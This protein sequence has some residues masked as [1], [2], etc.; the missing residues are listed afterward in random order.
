MLRRAL[1]MGMLSQP[2]PTDPISGDTWSTDFSDEPLGQ[3][4]AELS[5]AP[6]GA[7]TNKFNVVEENAEAQHGGRVLRFFATG[8]AQNGYWVPANMQESSNIEFLIRMRQLSDRN[9]LASPMLFVNETETDYAQYSNFGTDR[10]LNQSAQAIMSDLPTFDNTEWRWLR[11]QG[12]SGASFTDYRMKSWP[13]AFGDEPQ[14]WDE[15][16]LE[17]PV[18]V[19]LSGKIGFRGFRV[20]D[21]IV[22]YMAF[23]RVL[24]TPAPGPV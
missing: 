1:L 13:G 23:S 11:I 17:Y 6:W 2:E 8:A 16:A 21:A 10:L 5:L 9:I 20:G 19:N 12:A 3:P 18:H 22:D 15:E 7:T 24:G 4:F 14:A